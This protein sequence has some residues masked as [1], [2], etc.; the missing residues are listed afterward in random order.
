MGE[1]GVGVGMILKWILRNRTGK[2]GPH[3]FDSG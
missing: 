2:R 1:F 3:S